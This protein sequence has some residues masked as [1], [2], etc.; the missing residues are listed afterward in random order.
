MTFYSQRN[1]WQDQWVDQ[2]LAGKENGVFLDVGC[3]DWSRINN[4]LYFEESKNWSGFAIDCNPDVEVGWRYNRPNSKFVL[5]DATAIDYSELLCDQPKQIDYLSLDLE[6]PYLTIRALRRILESGYRFSCATIEHDEYRIGM[7]MRDEMRELM[8]K[9][10][11]SLEETRNRQDDFYI[12]AG[13]KN[14]SIA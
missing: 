1:T 3:G 14:A 9:H 12:D 5:A 13:V 8:D 6:P 11:Y 10:G 7:N 4:T 2:K